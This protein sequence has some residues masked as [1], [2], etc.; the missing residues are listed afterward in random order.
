MIQLILKKLPGPAL[1]AQ[2]DPET[3]F[4]VHET[5]EASRILPDTE[6][7]Q[8]KLSTRKAKSIC[9]RCTVRLDCL[10]EAMDNKIDYG[11]WGGLSVKERRALRKKQK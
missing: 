7:E 1:C 8:S 10:Q 5:V 3:W 9:Q 6:T 11:I 4:P 2:A